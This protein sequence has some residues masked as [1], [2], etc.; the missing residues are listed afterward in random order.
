MQKLGSEMKCQRLKLAT[1]STQP[2][3]RLSLFVRPI[4]RT[5]RRGELVFIPREYSQ[6][7]VL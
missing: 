1:S 3:Y 6:C 7:P 2:T 4:F 5:E